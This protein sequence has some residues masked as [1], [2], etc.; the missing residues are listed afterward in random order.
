MDVIE[1]TA[2]V[3]SLPSVMQQCIESDGASHSQDFFV[4]FSE[5]V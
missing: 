2:R 4:F 3:Y 5:F 1:E